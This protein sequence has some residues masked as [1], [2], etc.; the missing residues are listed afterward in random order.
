MKRLIYILLI[1]SLILLTLSVYANPLI[2]FLTKKQLEKVFKDSNVT[3]AGCSFNPARHLRLFDIQIRNNKVY[4]FKVKEAGFYYNPFFLFTRG[5]REFYL[6]DAEICLNLGQKGISEFAKYIDIGKRSI[7]PVGSLELSGLGLDIRSRDLTL[8]G[9]LSV[10][11]DLAKQLLSHSYLRIDSLNIQGLGL[12]NATFRLCQGLSNSEFYIGQVQYNKLKLRE[13][14]AYPKLQNNILSLD[15]LSAA[16]LDGK[17]E[18]DLQIG[19]HP[20]V[21]YSGR[22]NFSNLDLDTFI[23]DFELEEKVSLSGRVGGAIT[24][25]GRGPQLSLLSGGLTVDLPGGILTIKDVK[26]LENLA[27]KSGE[28]MDILMES[29]TNYSYNTAVLKLSLDKGDLICNIALE[30]PSGKRN[31]DITLHDFK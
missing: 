8:R 2:I 27:A 14:K 1:V 23:K 13:I 29:F 11:I 24:L 25:R 19:L 26:F 5:I 22:L 7:F 10:G 18:G 28:S 20:A 6:K 12:D 31:L 17:L 9:N 3:V 30:G 16:L 4:D 15:S 21:E